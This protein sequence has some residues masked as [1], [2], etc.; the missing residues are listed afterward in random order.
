VQVRDIPSD[1]DAHKPITP[2]LRQSTTSKSPLRKDRFPEIA[3]ATAA[4]IPKDTV[5]DGEV[6][7]WNGA[8]LDFELLQQRLAG[9]AARIARQ[10]REHPA[11]YVVFDVLAINGEDL[12]NRPL[13]ERRATLENM[14]KQWAP[15][16]QLS[17]LTDDITTAQAWLTDYR[18]AGIEGLVIKGAGTR[19]EPNQ[20]RWIKVK[21]RESI[22]VIMGAVIGPIDRPE[23]I[24]AGLYR[25]GTLVIA[26]SS[27]P[28][29]TVQPVPW[30]NC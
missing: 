29:T 26:G 1:D 30:Q 24:V 12:R 4:V 23:S 5:L 6:V 17:P 13:R 9:G 27:V 28:L 20:H 19:Y 22:E 2:P 15:P 10:V 8:R 11:S 16:L 7:V 18:Q 3:S 21:A 25:N 14:A